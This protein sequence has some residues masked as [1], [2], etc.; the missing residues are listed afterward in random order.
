LTS[1]CGRFRSRFGAEPVRTTTH[2][3]IAQL[4]AC[5]GMPEGPAQPGPSG[6]QHPFAA[7]TLL[8]SSQL[9]G[10]VHL[11]AL[12]TAGFSV[13]IVPR[14]DVSS[15]PSAGPSVAIGSVVERDQPSATAFTVPID[16]LT[17]HV[18]VAG[19]TGSGKSNSVLHLIRQVAVAGVPFLVVEPAKAEYRALLRDPIVGPALRVF[20]LGRETVSPLRLNPF[21]VPD[22]A[23]IGGHV[24][25]L[26]AVFEGAFGMWAPLP[27]VLERCLHEVYEDRGWDLRTDTNHRLDEHAPAWS[28]FPTLSDL[29]T[30]VPTVTR[31]LGYDAEVTANIEAALTTRI[32][33]LRLGGKGALLDVPRSLPMAELLAAPTVIELESMGSDDDKAFVMGLLLVRL[34]EYRRAQGQR[35]G[36]THLFVVEEAHRLLGAVQPVR[37]ENVADPR[38]S[39]VESFT[40]L[41]SEIRAYGQGVVIA[42]QVPTRLAP[43]VLKNTLLKLAHRTVAADDRFALASTMSMDQAQSDALVPLAVGR[44]AAFGFGADAPVL[45]QV[46]PTKDDKLIRDTDDAAVRNAMAA[47]RRAGRWNE[48]WLAR[49][50]CVAACIGH[51]EDAQLARSLLDQRLV[52]RTFTRIVLSLLSDPTSLE[53]TWQDLVQIVRPH[54]GPRIEETALLRCLAAHAPDWYAER[55][56]AQAEWTYSATLQYAHRLRQALLAPVDRRPSEIDAFRTYATDQHACGAPP[57]PACTE[58]CPEHTCLYRGAAADLV[59]EGRYDASLGGGRCRR[60]R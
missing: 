45:V 40:N 1:A 23:S 34:A 15:P 44:A 47:W 17:R 54:Q 4:A 19:V 13:R 37:S 24:D 32:N 18:F 35:P 43:E 38:G 6:Y 7:Q 10:Y 33:S 28:A 12:E 22:G 50:S 46:P 58:V 56:G 2:P 53:R 8:S 14:F 55:R 52:R 25:L 49:P 36:L 41:L 60:Q 5:W 21:D 59:A 20:T 57:Y 26:R 27:Q 11:P 31:S 30:K 9:A 29:A 48:L 39:A 3:T 51:D 42:D 16:S